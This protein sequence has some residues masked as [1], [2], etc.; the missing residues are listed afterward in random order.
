[1][2]IFKIESKLSGEKVGGCTAHAKYCGAGTGNNVNKQTN[3][4]IT[5]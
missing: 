1:L 4:R 2:N 5:C 3:W